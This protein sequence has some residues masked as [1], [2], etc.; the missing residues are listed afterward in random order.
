MVFN[1]KRPGQSFNTIAG[2]INDPERDLL[3]VEISLNTILNRETSQQQMADWLVPDASRLERTGF[4]RVSAL[5]NPDSN[6]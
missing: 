6:T 2:S 4:G 5:L 3:D 1:D